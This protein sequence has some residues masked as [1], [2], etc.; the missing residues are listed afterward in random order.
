MTVIYLSDIRRDRVPVNDIDPEQIAVG[1]LSL[2]AAYGTRDRDD[3]N[4]RV[5]R[6]RDLVVS[7][8]ALADG[9]HVVT[10]SSHT[11]GSDVD[12]F[13]AS[14][15]RTASGRSVKV[16]YC[17]PGDWPTRIAVAFMAFPAKRARRP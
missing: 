10:V 17:E 15:R 4:G 7:R 13:C 8:T 6:Y 3:R 16:G 11:R 2:V 14:I 12:L 1:L 5:C 9:E